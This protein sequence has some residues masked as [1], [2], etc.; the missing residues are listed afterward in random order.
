[1]DEDKIA[2]LKD[3]F[4]AFFQHRK[5]ITA[6]ENF[7][8]TDHFPH[9]T[10]LTLIKKCVADGFLTGKE[11]EFLEYMLS[12]YEIQYLDW[13][14]KTGWVKKQMAQK[15]EAKEKKSDQGVFDFSMSAGRMA[16]DFLTPLPQKQSV[17]RN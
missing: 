14:Q 12:R 9:R 2:D 10:Y 4:S 17:L 8:T 7:S 1:M 6:L 13:C 15:N 3:L 5:K 16:L 11:S